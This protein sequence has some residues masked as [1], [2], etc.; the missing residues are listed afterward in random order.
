MQIEQA[1]Q[2]FQ[3]YLAVER[4]RS[5]RTV[6]L[7]GCDLC[8]FAAFLKNVYQVSEIEEVTHLEIRDWLMSEHAKSPF[9]IKQYVAVLRS[10]YKYLRREHIV[11]T[12]VMAKVA[13]PK[14]PKR[15]PI[16]YTEKE[17]EKVYDNQYFSDDFEGVRDQLLLRMLYETGVRRAEVLGLTEASVDVHAKVLKVLGKGDKERL[18]PIEN[19]LLHNISRYLALKKEIADGTEAFFVRA[20]GKAF[21]AGDVRKVVKKYMTVFSNADRISPHVFRHSFATHM[22]NEG[23]DINAIKELLGHTD[24]AATEV[25]TH[26]S[27]QYMQETYRHTHPRAHNDK[28]KQ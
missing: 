1:I 13:T 5:K 4:R 15:L 27:R 20:N 17:V 11:A 18:I 24:L 21:A 9:T 2:S 22:L 23:A 6:E 14:T 25:Y 12:D 3:Q 7:Y 19:E 8:L 10:W 26:V 16:S 28:D